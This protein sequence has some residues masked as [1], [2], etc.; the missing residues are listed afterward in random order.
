MS[1]NPLLH[2]KPGLTMDQPVIVT[3]SAADWCI[4]MAW[5]AGLA[6]GIED[7]V[8]HLVY[9]VISPQV[10]E[11]VY[12]KASIQAVNAHMAE[13]NDP[14]NHPVLRFMMPGNPVIP[15]PEDFTEGNDE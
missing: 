9:G 10:A 1:N 5:H 12:D 11:A 13:A 14:S 4:L 2:Y 15:S 8:A 7:G 3:M 6:A